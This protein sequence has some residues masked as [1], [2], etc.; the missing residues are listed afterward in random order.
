[1]KSSLCKHQSF[2]SRLYAILPFLRDPAA[3][4][5]RQQGR[6]AR[7]T[8]LL[9]SYRE[10]PTP[11][12]C[13]NAGDHHR[14]RQRRADEASAP[15]PGPQPPPPSLPKRAAPHPV[16]AYPR[17]CAAPGRGRQAGRQAAQRSSAPLR[18]PR[19]SEQPPLS[20]GTA[21]PAR[22]RLLFKSS[23]W[24]RAAPR[25]LLAVAAAKGSTGAVVLAGRGR[26][27]G[28]GG[29]RLFAETPLSHAPRGAG[30]GVVGGRGTSA[31]TGRRSGLAGPAPWP[32]L[33]CPPRRLPRPGFASLGSGGGR[34]VS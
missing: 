29:G 27:T 5:C 12:A 11:P 30:A 6:P 8:A 16:R 21:L 24:R 31:A 7:P 19:T 22:P 26:P 17:A 13:R 1:V 10:A 3:R 33:V 20:T 4:L 25:G 32:A 28:L 9:R 34:C 23:Q 18:C 14:G 15:L 2:T